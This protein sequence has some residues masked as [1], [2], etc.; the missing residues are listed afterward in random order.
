MQVSDVLK[1][2]IKESDHKQKAIASQI[3]LNETTFSAKLNGHRK[4]YADEFRDICLVLVLNADDILRETVEQK[5]EER[6]GRSCGN[7]L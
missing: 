7:M 5:T 3:G 2:R 6:G 4:L 1:R